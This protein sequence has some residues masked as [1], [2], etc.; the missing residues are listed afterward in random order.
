MLAASTFGVALARLRRERRLTQAELAE[1][2]GLSQ[3]HISFLESGR[4]K[5]GAEALRKLIA[6][7]RLAPVDAEAFCAA[8]GL[9]SD[10]VHLSWHDI[11]MASARN[12]A[13]VLL[14]RHNPFP[15][16]VCARSGAIVQTNQAFDC[17]LAWAFHRSWPSAI[18]HRNIYDITLH[19]E[20]LRALMLNPE[21]IVPHTVRRLRHAA[22]SCSEASL[23]LNRLRRFSADAHWHAPEPSASRATST[24]IEHYIVRRQH[25]S[26][27][28]ATLMIGSQEDIGARN[29]FMEL[30]F[31]EDGNSARILET[32]S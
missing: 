14:S 26:V 15:G 20:G 18:A 13:N 8:I 1:R 22:I 31:P 23:T 5:P 6:G 32:L 17:V 7:L 2:A 3:R 25:L 9:G 10:A 28:S 19:P 29:F 30:Y 11:A 21:D 16:V 12:A 4:S 27:V 24:L